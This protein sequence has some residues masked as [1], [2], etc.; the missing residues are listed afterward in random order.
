MTSARKYTKYP[1]TPHL[2]WSPGAS[3]DDIWFDTTRSFD[4]V[5]VIV[6]EKMDGEN[7][8]MYRDHI[9]ARSIDSRHHPSRSWVKQLHQR[10]AH[11]I[12]E[13]WRLCGE[14]MYAR[15]SIGYDELP[16]FFMLFSIWT[17]ENVT[18]SWEETLEWAQLLELETVPVMWQ[19]AWDERA[20]RGLSFDT[21]EVEGYVVRRADG[22]AYEDFSRNVAKWVR[23]NHVQTEGH[24]MFAEVI[25]NGLAE[26]S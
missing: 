1:R 13:G 2:A 9:H 14:N 3:A 26:Q 25:P 15:H 8:T 16:S 20:I 21:D 7:T 24:W 10:I 12:P 5:E 11:Q 19:G 6:T 18:L 23:A 22:F 4:G 17:D